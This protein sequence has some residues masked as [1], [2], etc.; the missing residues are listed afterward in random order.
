MVFP[1]D[2]SIELDEKTY[3]CPCPDVLISIDNLHGRIDTK[4]RDLE[5][6]KEHDQLTTIHS[7]SDTTSNVTPIP[8]EEAKQDLDDGIPLERVIR[9]YRG[10]SL[11]MNYL[12]KLRFF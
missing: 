7:P 9:D 6:Q 4:K 12:E 2:S 10:F 5:K 3:N 8:L 1:E 11:L